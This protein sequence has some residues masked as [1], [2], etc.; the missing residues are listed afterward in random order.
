MVVKHMMRLPNNTHRSEKDFKSGM[1][2]EID[3]EAQRELLLI[4]RT[5]EMRKNL[6][7]RKGKPAAGTT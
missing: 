4:A 3:P 6:Q 7:G 1:L 2:F 5:M